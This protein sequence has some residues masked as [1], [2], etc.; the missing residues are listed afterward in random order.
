MSSSFCSCSLDIVLATIPVCGYFTH[1][2]LTSFLAGVCVVLISVRTGFRVSALDLVSNA[3][4]ST[5]R[6]VL[7]C[8]SLLTCAP[9]CLPGSLDSSGRDLR[10][11]TF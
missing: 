8:F 4:L 2:S 11:R 9:F 1:I 7:F 5:I 3:D 6:F 10:I